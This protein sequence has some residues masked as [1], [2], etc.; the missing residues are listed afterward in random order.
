MPHPQHLR[1]TPIASALG[2]KTT[3]DTREFGRQIY[4]WKLE[5][6]KKKQV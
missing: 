5:G 3:A 4:L 2:R 1:G 6:G